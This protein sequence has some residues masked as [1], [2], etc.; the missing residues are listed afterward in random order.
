MKKLELYLDTANISHVKTIK[1]LGFLDGVTSNPSI[2]AKENKPPI[3]LIKEI[4]KIIEG[5][6]WYQVTSDTSEEMIEEALEIVNICK[7]PVV[8]KFPFSLESLA[9]IRILTD[10]GIETNATLVYTIPQAIFAAKAGATYISPYLGRIDDMGG[11]SIEFINDL[12]QSFINLNFKTK[13]IGA[14][15]RNAQHLVDLSKE[16]IDALTISYDVFNKMLG[17]S[18]TSIGLDQF[19]QDWNKIKN[20]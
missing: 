19:N 15:I 1:K 8:I 3:K 12:K 16:G 13:I 17:H 20:L 18:M 9:G 14:S 11:S 4:D 7:N 2:L 6:I 5:K 10:K